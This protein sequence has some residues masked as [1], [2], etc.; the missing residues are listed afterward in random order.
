MR[1]FFI[2]LLVVALCCATISGC[3]SHE[4]ST[5]GENAADAQNQASSTQAPTIG[6]NADNTQGQT[7]AT[8]APTAGSNADNTQSQTSATQTPT[9]GSNDLQGADSTAFTTDCPY[10][11]SFSFDSFDEF[12]EAW[13]YLSTLP[14][15]KIRSVYIKNIEDMAKAMPYLYYLRYGD[16]S[17]FPI[18]DLIQATQAS[19]LPAAKINSKEVSQ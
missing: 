5:N 11:Q 7:S 19:T 6:N 9:N 12:L 15:D 17:P 16:N 14:Y 18:P 4:Q 10:G 3:K 1:N 2:L 13:P 8:Q